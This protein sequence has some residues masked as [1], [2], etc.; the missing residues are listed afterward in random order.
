MGSNPSRGR[1]F[2]ENNCLGRVVLCCFVFLLCCVALPYFLSISWMIKS[3]RCMGECYIT[4]YDVA[5]LRQICYNNNSYTCPHACMLR[6][7]SCVI[8]RVVS[9]LHASDTTRGRQPFC[10]PIDLSSM[11]VSGTLETPS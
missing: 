2:F 7:L 9:V 6:R 1:F 10:K 3:C 5:H 4:S 11:Q 8:D